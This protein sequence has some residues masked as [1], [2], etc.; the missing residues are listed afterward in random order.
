M[1]MEFYGRAFSAMDES[2]KK[3]KWV[4]GEICPL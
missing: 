2:L 4:S 3:M 1:A